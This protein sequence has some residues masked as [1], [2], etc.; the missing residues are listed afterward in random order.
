MPINRFA[1]EG[2]PLVA[3][4]GAFNQ[5]RAIQDYRSTLALVLLVAPCRRKW[6]ALR[7]TGPRRPGNCFI[8]R[9]VH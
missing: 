1:I 4:D 6:S 7:A 8:R 9:R 3:S 5:F 2:Y